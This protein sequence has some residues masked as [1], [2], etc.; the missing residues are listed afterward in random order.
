VPVGGLFAPRILADANTEENW[1][2][3]TAALATLKARG[4]MDLIIDPVKS[5]AAVPAAAWQKLVDHLDANG[6]RYGVGFGTGVGLPLSGTVVK[7]TN[8][9]MEDVRENVDLSWSVSEADSGYFV[10]VDGVDATNIQHEGRVR[11]RNGNASVPGRTGVAQGSVAIFYPHKALGPNAQGWVPD[12]WEGFDRYRDR[13]IATFKQVKFGEGLRFFHDPLARR[14]ALLGE[15]EYLVPDSPGFQLEWEAWLTSR[16]PTVDDLMNAWGLTDR[17][18]KDFQQAARMIPLAA[19]NRG[20]PYML[21]PKDNTRQESRSTERF[22]SDLREC[23]N[24]SLA[25]YMGAASEVLKRE[26]A[27]V[28][29]VYTRTHYHRIFSNQHKGPGYSGFDGLGMAAYGRGS[30]IVTSGADSVYSQ[31]EE[32]PRNLWCIVTETQDTASPGKQTLGYASK[33][34][35]FYDMD[36]LRGIGA[37]GFFVNALQA[38]PEPQYRNFSLVNS[39]EQVGWLKEYAERLG[40]GIV[41]EGRPH[42]L[43]YPAAAEGIVSAGPIGSRGTYWVLSGTSGKALGYGSSYNGY[44]LNEPTGDMVVMWS[45]RGP[46]LTR[47]MVS[48]PRTV[49]I[50]TPEGAPVETKIDLKKRTVAV[51]M[52]AN[53]LVIRNATADVFPMEAVEDALVELKLLVEEGEKNKTA[54]SDYGLKLDRA[55]QNYR[56]REPRVALLQAVEALG[57]IV[58]LIQP[59]TWL[60]A[61]RPTSHTFNE[62]VPHQAASGGGIAHLNTEARPSGQGY[63]AVYNFSVPADDS[64]TLWAAVTPPGP[65]AS[66]FVWI[67]DNNQYRSSTEGQIVGSPYLA[68]QFVWMNLGR[69]PLRKGAHTL[70]VRVTDLAP[71]AARYIFAADVFLLTRG[72]FTPNGIT[73]PAIAPI[74]TPESLAAR[75]PVSV[76]KKK[77]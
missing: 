24:E 38:L 21:D 36:W 13:L 56:A 75:K 12:V 37:K 53:P 77:K 32:A 35:L 66:P 28:P 3:D 5:A 55:L 34:A 54:I 30:A 20:V 48:D 6:F 16:Y 58:N 49:Q 14:I 62:L 4:V 41:A 57:G 46:R 8:Y 27:D 11:A 64:Y 39:P 17:N 44:V 18:I 42:T 40:R 7:P 26:I 52:D 29:V 60:E 9:R 15:V 70:T 33:D 68:N 63:G 10:L 51:M 74:S 19:A 61:E 23:R 72:A 50:T 65:N 1:T 2:K 43:P 69:V 76:T 25:Y 71:G 73:K 59:Y 67:V 31:A 22:W 47:L 45:L